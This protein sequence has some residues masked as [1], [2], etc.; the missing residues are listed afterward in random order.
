MRNFR[1]A[2]PI[3]AP[4]VGDVKGREALAYTGTDRQ[5]QSPCRLDLE[6]DVG[7]KMFT[8]QALKFVAHL[9]Y[10]DKPGANV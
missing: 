1:G 8:G 3:P 6:A 10:G 9:V 2:P 7:S 4:A 5:S